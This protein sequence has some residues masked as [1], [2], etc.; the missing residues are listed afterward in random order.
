MNQFENLI[1]ASIV[2]MVQ[3][4]TEFLPISSSGHLVI[5]QRLL[6]ID[7]AGIS[8]EI[9]THVATALAV[10]LFL[11][12]RIMAIVRSLYVYASRSKE[13]DNKDLRTLALVLVGSIPAGIVGVVFRSKIENLFDRPVFTALMLVVTGCFLLTCF[14]AS[15]KRA[16]MGFADA[17][18]VGLAQ[19]IAVVPGISRS[20]LTIGASLLI[21]IERSEAFEFSMLLSLPAILGAGLID[22]A[23][24][25][26]YSASAVVAALFALGFGCL[27]LVWL[28]KWVVQDFF[29]YFSFYVIPVGIAMAI[30]LR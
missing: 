8:V 22:V 4:L 28:R 7:E 12:K 29:P 15:P 18:I 5:I 20:G 19:A 21:G 16:R 3:G 30:L 24:G 9:L 11:R 10:I 27:G 1:K 13:V 14:L 2:G 23:K 17:L 6:G 26:S 25:F